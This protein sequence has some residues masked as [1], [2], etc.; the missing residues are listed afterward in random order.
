MLDVMH[1]GGQMGTPDSGEL[2]SEILL[3]PRLRA[4][5]VVLEIFTVVST[6]D[7]TDEGE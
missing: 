6:Y 1:S 3:S 7:I 4:E 5:G 2:T